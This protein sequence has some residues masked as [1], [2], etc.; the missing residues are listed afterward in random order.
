MKGGLGT[1]A[2]QEGDL[3]VGAIVAVNCLGDVIDSKTGDVVA[4]VLNEDKF[5]FRNTEQIMISKYS[6]NKNAF[7]GNTT[8]GAIVTNARLTKAEINKVASMAHNGYARSIY[9]VH[10]MYDGDTIFSMATGE[11]IGRAHV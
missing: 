9:P 2:V 3:M 6:D 4:G 11:E 5:G 10:T 7:N 8:I 1:Y